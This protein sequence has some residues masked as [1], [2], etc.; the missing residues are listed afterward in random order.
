MS[1]IKGRS[2]RR[3]L[4]IV[5]LRARATYRS[6]RHHARESEPEAPEG[7]PDPRD[8]AGEALA[9]WHRMIARLEA[10][11][12]LSTVDDAALRC[13]C[14]LHADTYSIDSRR[15]VRIVAKLTRETRRLEASA[16]V[17]ALAEIVQLEKLIAR[18]IAQRRQGAMA[19]RQWLCEFGCT[20]SSRSRVTVTTKAPTIR[21]E[22]QARFFGPASQLPR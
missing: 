5:V 12:T 14:T 7:R 16:L 2:G 9:E 20:P 13:Y 3:P 6:D 8:L 19:L 10:I 18:H 4:P 22:R 15:L 17:A 11:G 1:G 21:S